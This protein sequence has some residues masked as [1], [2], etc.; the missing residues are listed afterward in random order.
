[1]MGAIEMDEDAEEVRRYRHRAV[2][3]RLIAADI[4][5]KPSREILIHV[6]E[7]SERMA[8]A[9]EAVATWPKKTPRAIS[10]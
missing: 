4:K 5:D 9:R 7:D 3:L 6:A 8:T 10:S 1:M 2:Q